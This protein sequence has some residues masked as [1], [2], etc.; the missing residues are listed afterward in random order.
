MDTTILDNIIYGRSVPQIYAFST[1]TV[2]NYL[3]VGDTYRPLEQRLDEWRVPYPDL[4][5]RC[6][7]DAKVDDNT[8]FR[9]YSVH[10]YL[11]ENHF[12]RL[13]PDDIPGIAYYSNEFFLGAKEKD[14]Y[15]AIKD[16]KENYERNGNKYRYYKFEDNRVP[17]IYTYERNQDFSPRDNQQQT[18]DNFLRAVHKGR[19]NL[20]MY[21]VMRFGKSFTAMCCASEIHASL[22]LIVSAKADVREEWKRTVESHIRFK[23]YEFADSYTLKSDYD[24]INNKKA[25][26]E[27][28]ALFLTL[29]DLEGD[30]IKERHKELFQSEIDLLIIDET[31]FGARAPEYGKVLMDAGIS[32]RAAKKEESLAYKD[33]TDISELNEN[34][35]TLNAKIKLHLSGTPYR[36][37]MGDE[38]A[39]EDIIAFYQYTDIVNDQKRWYNEH[40]FEDNFK[41]WEN[42]YYGFPE[43]IRFAFNPPAAVQRRLQELK[44]NG[45]TY[46]LSSLF[47]PCSITRAADGRHKKFENEEYVYDL[48][49]AIDGSKP[50]DNVL[51]FLNYDKIKEGKMCRHIVCVLPYCAS[52]DALENLLLS[53]KEDF[54]NLNEY[55][56]INISGVENNLYPTTQS[57]INKIAE[58][59]SNNQK[60]ITLTVNRMLTGSTV[61]QWD[62]MLYLKGTY[63]P[64]E[65]D[66][67]IFRLQNQYLTTY[68]G[69]ENKEIKYNMKPQTLL[70]DF[71]PNRMFV[72]QELKSQIYNC[73]TEENGNLR[74]AE[75][76]S[77]ELEVS[78]IIYLNVNK[79][80]RV[81]QQNIFDAVRQYSS[82]KSVIDEVSDIPDDIILLQ[83]E[84]IKLAIKNIDPINAKRGFTLR[85]VN[86]PP[87]GDGSDWNLDDSNRDTS[88]PEDGQEDNNGNSDN[89]ENTD[90][91]E[92][93]FAKK[94]DTYFAYI[95]FFAFLTESEVSSLEEIINKIEKDNN[96]TRIAKNLGLNTRILKIINN[97]SNHFI[98][99][100]LDYKIQNINT[101]ARDTS[102][103]PVERALV[104]LKKFKRFSDSEIVT[105]IELA[106]DVVSCLPDEASTGKILD[107][108]SKQGEFAI[109][110]Y[111]RF[112]KSFINNIYAIPTSNLGYEFTRKIYS[113]LGIPDT[114]ILSEFNSYSLLSENK[115]TIIK[116]LSDM[117]FKAIV[118]NP[119]YQ[120]MDGGHGPSGTPIYHKFVDVAKTLN[121]DYI[122]MIIQSRWFT[123]GKQAKEITEFRNCM[124]NDG[125]L[126][127][128][129]DYRKS[130]TVFSGVEIK[131]GVC[132]FLW[133]KNYNNPNVALFTHDES[134]KISKAIR[135]L[136]TDGLVIRYSEA[137]PIFEKVKKLSTQ[138]MDT[139]VSS[140][141][142]FGLPTNF[143]DYTLTPTKE[144]DIKIYANQKVGYIDKSKVTKHEEWINKYKVFIPEAIG[145]GDISS[146][147]IK[148]ILGEPNSVCTE[149]YVVFDTFDNISEAENAISFIKTKFFHL[150]LGL[151][152][153]TQHTSKKVYSCVPVEDFSHPWNDELLY[154][155]YSLS[156]KEI[157]FINNT[158]NLK[159]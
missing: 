78:P 129:H 50:D 155:K 77:E 5:K 35:K 74:L 116:K 133:D 120:V 107:I 70:V 30:E 134:G 47:K 102:L 76:I 23:D 91:E 2:P 140:R 63:S 93:D 131:G 152:K 22:V 17:I 71:D 145:V 45:H 100:K 33:E 147:T 25:N 87:N 79:L 32:G 103:E 97:R 73:N 75:R 29:Q 84:D 143:K 130:S 85:A 52:C 19:K 41:E 137:I 3:K 95:L 36:I 80:E 105:P 13:S 65:Y 108:A 96:D 153:N 159:Y 124:A 39:A 9:D 122:S 123:G 40:H 104:A 99:S 48:F 28:V 139:I 94:L 6:N 148:P 69:D 86:N 112:G 141:K 62:T 15:N 49:A 4:I 101:L 82:E 132:Y 154:N 110:L 67:A 58:C 156:T 1:E 127:I 98:L 38:F 89:N 150:M 7:A 59:E 55:E 12:Q 18:I 26:N 51:S 151:K 34:I 16:I 121:P 138:F 42:P 68:K 119:P 46:A 126:K 54:Y 43:M 53:H 109:S 142:P 136:L 90:N 14:V 66:Q 111:N 157:N 135:P 115:E 88:L 64:Q 144:S 44:E 72:M 11:R 146:D 37:L 57:V 20:L 83:D 10:Q 158:I 56:I 60:T 24:Y 81:T 61:E 114:N 27:K 118:G 8:F 128:L 125:H 149:T 117:K 21:A 92:E 31:H 106:D 113:Y